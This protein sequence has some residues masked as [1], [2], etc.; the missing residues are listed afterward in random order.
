[1]NRSLF[2]V[3]ALVGL[4]SYAQ[5]IADPRLIDTGYQIPHENYVDQPYVVITSDGNWLCVLT[6]GVGK[7]GQAGQHIVSTISSDRGKT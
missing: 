3:S 6:T 1:M 4:A 7:E 2:I 5:M